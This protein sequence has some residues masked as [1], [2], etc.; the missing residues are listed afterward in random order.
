MHGTACGGA[1]VQSVPRAAMPAASSGDSSDGP[2][3]LL[4]QRQPVLVARAARARVQAPRLPIAR[5]AVLEAG[6]QVAADAADEPAR[7]R[8]GAQGRRAHRVRVAC[9]P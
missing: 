2:R 6:A 1:S 7:A 3:T 4:G 9:L 8:A 5:A